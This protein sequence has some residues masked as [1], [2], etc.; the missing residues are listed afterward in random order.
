MNV[1][2]LDFE[3]IQINLEVVCVNISSSFETDL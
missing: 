1:D 3:Y 2:F